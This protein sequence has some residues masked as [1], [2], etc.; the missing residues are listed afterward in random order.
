VNRFNRKAPLTGKTGIP[1]LSGSQSF[2]LIAD[3][4]GDQSGLHRVC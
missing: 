2:W 3:V 4:K 1:F